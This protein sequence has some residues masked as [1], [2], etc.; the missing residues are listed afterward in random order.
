MSLPALNSACRVVAATVLA[1][2][3]AVGGWAQDSTQSAPAS[4]ATVPVH[5]S[6]GS[7]TAAVRHSGLLQTTLVRFPIRLRRTR[8]NMCLP[9]IEQYATDRPI[10]A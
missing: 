1:G 2:A 3:L 9:R 8:R 10:H 7:A 4:S 6:A 5:S